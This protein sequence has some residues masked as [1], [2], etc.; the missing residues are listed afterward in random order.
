[1]SCLFMIG[2]LNGSFGLKIG[3]WGTSFPTITMSEIG[4]QTCLIKGT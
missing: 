4:L 2:V 1:M 3:I